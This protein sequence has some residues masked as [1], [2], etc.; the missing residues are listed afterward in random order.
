MKK[1]LSDQESGTFE[2][3]MGFF[4][5]VPPGAK[6][7]ANDMPQEILDSDKF[8][9]ARQS[10]LTDLEAAV[11][12]TPPS[13]DFLSGILGI[14]VR[15]IYSFRSKRDVPDRNYFTT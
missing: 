12:I 6:D 8:K 1:P 15:L 7:P 3:T 4:S 10:T 14:Q 2:Y 13:D 9:K 11:A 5:K